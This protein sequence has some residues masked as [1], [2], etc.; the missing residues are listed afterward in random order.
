MSDRI[1]PSTIP[2]CPWWC[3]SAIEGHTCE[4]DSVGAD[5]PL[6]HYR[7]HSH[8]FGEFVAVVQ[9]EAN[10]LGTIALDPVRVSVYVE[11]ADTVVDA[12]HLAHG[13]QEAADLMK[14]IERTD[15]SLTVTTR[16]GTYVVPPCPAWCVL[17]ADHDIDDPTAREFNGALHRMH[18]AGEWT[19]PTH[20][21]GE[22]MRVE[23][24][25]STIVGSQTQPEAD[26]PPSIL[27][28]TSTASL[29][30]NQARIAASALASAAD[31]LASILASSGGGER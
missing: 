2:P 9:S 21:A 29:D 23:V 12:Q 6:T 26:Q 1:D 16:A 27:V 13:L 19:V 25:W 3:T 5:D 24:D 8:S 4:Y 28:I 10:R 22:R 7:Y 17:P 14:R 30:V 11:A 18:R 31:T 15:E 20:H